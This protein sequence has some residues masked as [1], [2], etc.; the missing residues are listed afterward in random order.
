MDRDYIKN[1]S[2]KNGEELP[3]L[4]EISDDDLFDDSDDDEEETDEF[5]LPD[6][7]LFNDDPDDE[8]DKKVESKLKIYKLNKQFEQ[9]KVEEEKQA[10]ESKALCVIFTG[11]KQ[12][13]TNLD[14]DDDTISLEDK[15]EYLLND[16]VHTSDDVNKQ[17]EAVRKLKCKE[18]LRVVTYGRVSTTR[19][20]QE[21]SLIT[22]HKMF[23]NYVADNRSEGYILIKEVY[24][25]TSAKSAKGRPKFKKLIYKALD[26]SRP[27][28]VLMFKD[29]NRMCRNIQDFINIYRELLKN[30]VKCVFIMN[31]DYNDLTLNIMA[32]LAED[33]VK[34]LSN[35]VKNTKRI[36]MNRELG[37]VPSYCFGYDKPKINDSTVLNINETEANIVRE[38]F[39]RYN[40][41]EGLSTICK[42]FRLRGIKT[43]MGK[44]MSNK[45]LKAML[46]N[47]IYIGVLEMGLSYKENV[48]DDRIYL[49]EPTV[50]RIR[51]DLRIVSDEEFDKAQEILE[52]KKKHTIVNNRRTVFTSKV[53]CEECG[54][55][56]KN[57]KEYRRD[58]DGKVKMTV[59]YLKCGTRR[60][61]LNMASNVK[62]DNA[63]NLRRDA[64]YDLI[65]S[66]FKAMISLD[67]S[68]LEDLL[69]N[70]LSSYMNKINENNNTEYL[71]SEVSKAEAE[72]KRASE[73]A[74]MGCLYDPSVVLE[75]KK[76]YEELLARS[77]FV[78][79]AKVSKEEVK[80]MVKLLRANLN[81]YIDL[82]VHN[83]HEADE[84]TIIKF[85]SIFKNIIVHKDNRLTF[86]IRVPNNSGKYSGSLV[87]ILGDDDDSL[88]PLGG[89]CRKTSTLGDLHSNWWTG[90]LY[91]HENDYI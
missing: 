3:P 30:K 60:Q 58:K 6:D 77:K 72:W 67:E 24:E 39:N 56:Y 59:D 43:K 71:E 63:T 11:E 26:K 19:G 48:Y 17:L 20:E 36:N 81:N 79:R 88:P 66:Y 25:R 29:V 49:K 22:Q 86:N 83:M 70:V 65:S 38:L 7:L 75:K 50:V 62:C 51:P 87:K 85:N 91:Y 1:G 15:I 78:S 68:E 46:K 2:Y 74:V 40:N 23:N 69:F 35:N 82:V 41:L 28:D 61:G 52:G 10:F 55:S 21:S 18:P 53:I 80:S 42:D 89:G 33:F 54:R 34:D 31:K 13:L 14:L 90:K 57:Y 8:W 37:R 5:E 27:Y 32:T 64:L 45:R 16:V 44:E 12:P 73:L 76:K 9:K 84:Q 4:P 47:K